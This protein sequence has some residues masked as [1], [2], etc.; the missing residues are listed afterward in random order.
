[1]RNHPPEIVGITLNDVSI[2]QRA[3]ARVKQQHLV[4]HGEVEDA[5]VQLV[6]EARDPSVQGLDQLADRG[7][8]VVDFE[9]WLSL[10]R[11]V[12]GRTAR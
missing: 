2:H 11:S 5:V 9:T 10:T 7:D 1:M 3:F 4:V 12:A 8:A 6:T